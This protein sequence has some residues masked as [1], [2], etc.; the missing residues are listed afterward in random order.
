MLKPQ[1]M[2]GML[3]AG[4]TALLAMAAYSQDFPNKPVRI[5]TGGVG[6]PNDFASRLVAQDLTGTW[7]QQVIVDNRPNGPTSGDLVSKSAPDGYT[8]LV[9]VNVLWIGH[10]LY[11]NEPY[12][13]VRDFA[14]ITLAAIAPNVLVVHPS[15]PVKSVKE[16]IALAKAKPG[17]LNYGSGATGSVSHLGAELFNNMAQIKMVRI[18]YKNNT[19]QMSDLLGGHIQLI[20]TGANA[21]APLAR[22]GR[23]R[24]LGVTGAQR[25]AAFPDVPTIAAAGLPGYEAVLYLGFLAP[26]KTPATLINR[27][28]QDILRV[29]A[30]TD[31]KEKLLN[32]GLE[33]VASTP[34]QFASTIQAD[35]AR[36]SKVIKEAG[37]KAD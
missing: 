17:Q 18:P 2:T 24:A 15:L 28:N 9:A 4:L 12:D 33:T 25:V 37:I 8:L 26:A 22:S 35:I 36:W 31:V 19:T 21:A 11:E 20:F 13:P 34:A 30:K 6:G 16:L 32:A 10:L 7:G 14:P 29:L 5:I 27:L 3:L 1:R 23:L